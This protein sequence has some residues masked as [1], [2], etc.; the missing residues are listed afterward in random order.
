[1]VLFMLVLLIQREFVMEKGYWIKSKPYYGALQWHEHATGHRVIAQDEGARS[2][3]KLCQHRYPPAPLKVFLVHGESTP[4]IPPYPALLRQLVG[5]DLAV[6]D[7]ES[8]ALSALNMDLAECLMGTQFYVAG[9]EAF[10]WDVIAQL[11]AYGV[12]DQHVVK[13]LCGTLARAVYCVH[14]K[15]IDKAVHH[16]IF[17]CRGCG[18]HLFVRDHFSRR[19]GAYMG[20]MTDA[21]EP[22]NIPEI[23]EIYP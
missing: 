10:I 8:A 15:T 19:L 11:G 9:S 13:E 18:R 17:Q 6:F 2:V 23:K 1:M 21:E 16:N 5:K 4:S 7:S 12:Q 22:G 3:V 20:L 14:C